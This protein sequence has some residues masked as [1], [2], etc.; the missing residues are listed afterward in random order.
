MSDCIRELNRHQQLLFP[1]WLDDYV[2]EDAYVDGL[3]ADDLG[4]KTRYSD[5]NNNGYPP[6]AQN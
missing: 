3:E 1:D 5:K 6:F 2:S 4:F